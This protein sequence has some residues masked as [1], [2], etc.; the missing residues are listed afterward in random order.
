MKKIFTFLL[1]L[2]ASAGTL[3][4]ASGTC[5]TNVTWDLT[6]GVLTIS[7]T[8]AMTSW[9]NPSEVPWYTYLTAVKSVVIEDGCFR[10]LHKFDLCDDCQ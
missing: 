9:N 4:A 6:S 10:W 7:G 3:F 8:G 1:A 2:I 5:G